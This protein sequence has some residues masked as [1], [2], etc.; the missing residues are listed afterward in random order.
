V[1]VADLRNPQRLADVFT[2]EA[3][4]LDMVIA[5][6]EPGPEFATAVAWWRARRGRLTGYINS[7]KNKPATPIDVAGY[8]TEGGG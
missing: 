7:L 5:D 2:L 8:F 3:A 1:S 4:W 6:R